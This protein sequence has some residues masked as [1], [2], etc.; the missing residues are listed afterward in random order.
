MYIESDEELD[1]TNAIDINFPASNRLLCTKHLNDGT[2]AYLQTKV[3]VPQ[4]DRNDIQIHSKGKRRV[5]Q[6]NL[7]HFGM[8][9]M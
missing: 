4:K 1:L 3:G 6:Q 5:L 7:H 9:G 8:S 2:R